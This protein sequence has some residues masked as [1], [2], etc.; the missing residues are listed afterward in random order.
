MGLNVGLFC[1]FLTIVNCFN[2]KEPSRHSAVHDRPELGDFDRVET[3]EFQE[4]I[5]IMLGKKKSFDQLEP[6]GIWVKVSEGWVSQELCSTIFG[7]GIDEETVWSEDL[8]IVANVLGECDI[9]YDERTVECLVTRGNPLNQTY[10]SIWR[11]GLGCTLVERFTEEEI[12]A[13]D[14]GDQTPPTPLDP[15]VPWPHGEGYYPELTPEGIDMDCVRNVVDDQFSFANR[16]VN[17]RGITVVYKGHLAYERYKEG[18]TKETRLL[19]WS[20]TKSLTQA[21]I[22]I[23]VHEGRLDIYKPAQI[24]EWYENEGDPRQNITVDMMLRMS[25]G[26]RWTGDILPTTQCIFWSDCNCG[27]VCGLRPL[28]AEPDTLWDYNSGSSYLLSRLALATRGDP[29][30]TNYDWPKQKLYYPIGAYSMYI[31]YQANG[32]YLGGAYGYGIARD[33]AR[34]GL[35]FLRDGVWIDGRR[36]LPEG[37]TEYSGRTTHTNPSYAA[38]FWK[39][40]SVD[41]NLYFA[42]GFRN[43]Y[44]FI[45]PDQELVITFNAMTPFAAVSVFDSGAFLRQMLSCVGN[46]TI[47]N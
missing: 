34:F 27:R 26:T 2:I 19:A 6:D 8:G 18:I 33:W 43:Q 20:A 29:Q 38:H 42:Y 13:T 7:S 39:N 21:L 10:K 44:V 22:G 46:G 11:Q 35:L 36:I 14:V 23:L 45:F 12:R 37:W 41:P 47:V 9:N 40:P 25:S 4:L 16:R 24:P 3:E 31:E 1:L 5:D 30:F 32:D 28:V 17:A 15:L